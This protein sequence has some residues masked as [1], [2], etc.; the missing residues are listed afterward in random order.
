VLKYMWRTVILCTSS[1]RPFSGVPPSFPFVPLNINI[2]RLDLLSSQRLLHCHAGRCIEFKEYVKAFGK[3]DTL[4]ME[5]SEENVK[6]IGK[7]IKE[8]GIK[9]GLRGVGM[10]DAFTDLVQWEEAL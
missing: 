10:L 5:K 6:N 9:F 4:K 3:E 1:N 7:P 2:Y 8:L